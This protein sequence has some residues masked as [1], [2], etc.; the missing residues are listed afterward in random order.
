MER[1]YESRNELKSVS[2]EDEKEKNQ[3]VENLIKPEKEEIF[4][5]KFIKKCI[6]CK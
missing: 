5:I 2:L 6:C 3:F 1:K 4:F